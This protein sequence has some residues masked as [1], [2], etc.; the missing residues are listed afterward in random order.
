MTW[1]PINLALCPFC[2]FDVARASQVADG[3]RVI[4]D[5]ER[6]GCGAEGGVALTVPGA[7]GLWNGNLPRAGALALTSAAAKRSG[8]AA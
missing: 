7:V 1:Q 4:C 5:L 8:V 6:G 2:D 3:F